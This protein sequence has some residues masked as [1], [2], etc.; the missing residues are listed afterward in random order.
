MFIFYRRRLIGIA[1]LTGVVTSD[2]LYHT[3]SEFARQVLIILRG[4]LYSP[5][6]ADLEA[7]KEE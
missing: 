1:A 4:L 5:L 7:L 2:A 3:A 6:E